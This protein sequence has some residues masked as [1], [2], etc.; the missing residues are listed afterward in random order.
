MT[1]RLKLI[2]GFTILL[3]IF[4]IDFVVNQRLSREVLRNTNYISNSEMVIRNSNILHKEMIE[5]Q[6]GFR[7][8]LLTEQEVFLQPYFNGLQ[9]VPSLLKEQRGLV[10][11]LQQH[12]LDSIE[13]I[14]TQWVEYADSLIQ[15]KKDTMPGSGLTYRRLFESKLRMEV[16]K[17]LNDKIHRIFSNFDSAEYLLRQKRRAMLQHSVARTRM[18]TISLTVISIILALISSTYFISTISRRIS[19][20]V[21][22]AEQVSGGK[23]T[24]LE[25]KSRDEFNGLTEA[26]NQ[27]SAKLDFNIS[28]LT[29][30]NKELDQF[31]YVVSHDLK[32]PLRGISN[33]ISWVE[34]DHANEI[35]ANISKSL[36]LIKIRA[37]RL[38]NLINGL[39]EYA[40]AGKIKKGIQMTDVQ[41]LL[42]EFGDLL[43]PPD[44]QFVIMGMMPVFETEKLMLEQVFSNLI[45]N[46]VKYGG[47]EQ[48]LIEI[49]CRDLNDQ[50]E[51]SVKDYGPGI[52][53][54][55]FEK[56]F[57]IFQTLQERDAF[58]S[59]GVGL[60][61]VK[62]IIEEHKGHVRVESGA[63]KGATFIFTW[64]K[65]IT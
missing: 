60:A 38:E 18:I 27:M 14:H 21:R 56:I 23:F 50:Y 40:K 15:S 45:S 31:A 5:M 10:S 35:T 26:L 2:L 32:A 25:E 12:R 30:Q 3:L 62:K 11:E 39:L 34:E 41:Q 42:R 53:P 17:K 28:Q 59:T 47:G 55:Y 22:F 19:R 20:M 33:L 51:F 63:G 64:P 4:V 29:K 1:I 13:Q 57:V 37:R 8:F 54:S 6:S 9:T 52:E 16:G 49:S 7:G 24:Q 61:I 44:F 43:V 46:A 36:A 48:K 65:R 58:E